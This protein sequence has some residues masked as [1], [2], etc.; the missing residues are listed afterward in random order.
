M[1]DVF[2]GT[3]NT[4]LTPPAVGNQVPAPAAVSVLESTTFEFDVTDFSGVDT[5][6]LQVSLNAAP[7][8]VNGAAVSGYSVA[9][10]AIVD[11]YRVVITRSAPLDSVTTYSLSVTA[12]DQAPLYNEATYAWSFSTGDTALPLVVNTLPVDLSVNVSATSPVVFDIV[13]GAGSGI[14]LSTLS[15]SLTDIASVTTDV[16]VSGVPQP[17]FVVTTTVVSG[18]F[19]VS[20]T[21]PGGLSKDQTYTADV[22]VDDAAGNT[23]TGSWSWSTESGVVETPRLSAVGGQGQVYTSWYVNPAMSVES[24]V[25]RRSITSPPMDPDSGLLVYAGTEKKFIDTNVVDGQQYFYTVFVIRFLVSGVPQYVPYSPPAS[26]SATTTLVRV[27]APVIPEYVPVPQ[28]FGQTT[29]PWDGGSISQAWGAEDA[30]G[31]RRQSDLWILPRGRPIRAPVT[32]TITESG[33][34]AMVIETSLGIRISISGQLAPSPGT[35]PGT[36]VQTGD[37]LA[38]AGG[39]AVEFSVFR[40]PSGRDGLRSIRPTYFYRTVERRL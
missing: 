22:S 7:V 14:N 34:K 15:L 10:S 1:P 31:R 40:L 33:D 3:F 18:G 35:G 8:I 21:R 36:R 13:D 23:G 27:S 9:Y 16:I 5:A 25:L 20:V 38:S 4:D 29:M 32:G 12:R 26:A 11:G 2:F 17:P 19:R 6:F 28:E 37:L 30:G 39:G 24:F